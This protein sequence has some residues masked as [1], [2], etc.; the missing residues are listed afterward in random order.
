[1]PRQIA[2]PAGMQ[3]FGKVAQQRYKIAVNG[4]K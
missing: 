4:E 3:V 1:M 2:E